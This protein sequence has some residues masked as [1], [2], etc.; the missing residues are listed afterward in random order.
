MSRFWRLFS[1]PSTTVDV[2]RNFFN[3]TWAIYGLLLLS[4]W[5]DLII[6]PRDA[7]Y[8]E[9]LLSG[10]DFGVRLSGVIPMASSND[11]GTFSSL[12]ALVCLARLFPASDEERYNKPWYAAVLLLC[13]VSLVMSQTRAAIVSVLLGGAFILL[14]S[15]RGKFGALLS[16]LV[17][18]VVALVTMGGTVMKFMARGQTVAQMDS[19]SSR[20]E[21]WGLAWQSFLQQPLT[22]LGAYAAGRF[23]VLGKAGLGGTG[24]LHS[25]YLEVIVGTGIWGMVPLI[26]AL[27][28]TW[29][30]LLRFIRDSPDPQQRQLVHEALAILALLTFRSFFNNMMTI[31]PPLPFL[32]I[33]GYAEFLRR[34]KASIVHGRPF[35]GGLSSTG[36]GAAHDFVPYQETSL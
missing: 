30:I 20:T 17:V 4:V 7:L 29:W 18:P 15:K 34:R 19:L 24:T 23:A 10:A 25:D 28:G 36:G 2:Y 27:V 6:W 14:Y 11:V 35:L 32:A 21:W 31:H 5:K 22:G 12:L 33:L 3:W 1:R 9:N 8:G 26:A 16:F 13:V